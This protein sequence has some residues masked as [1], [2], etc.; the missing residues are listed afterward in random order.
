MTTAIR[1]AERNIGSILTLPG[2][3]PLS[4]TRRVV[5]CFEHFWVIILIR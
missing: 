3:R 1:S 2:F 5:V 4:R